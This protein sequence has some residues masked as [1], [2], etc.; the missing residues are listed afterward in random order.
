M[1]SEDLIIDTI[2]T[3]TGKIPIV[4]TALNYK[5]RLGVLKMRL[6]IGRMEYAI[7]PGLYAVGNPDERSPVLVSANYKLSF[8]YLRKELQNFNAW[9]L[10]LDTKGIN[11]WCA[12]GKGTFGTDELIN[13]IEA[14]KLGKIVN[15]RQVIL[16]Q[17]SA[18]GVAAHLVKQATGFK[19]RYGPIR[20]VDLPAF[21]QSDFEATE[22][23]R[24]VKFD[25]IDRLALIPLEVIKA[26]KYI[27]IGIILLFFLSGL[28]A[29]GY[30]VTIAASSL[31]IINTC[32]L[33]AFLAGAVLTPLLLPYIPGRAFALKG[34]FMNG[35]LFILLYFVL[36]GFQ[37]LHV[38]EIIAWFLMMSAIV[39]FFAMNFTGASTFTSLSGVKKEMRFAV[40]LQII[41]MA[42]GLLFWVVTRIA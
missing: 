39:S 1:I 11:V 18:P 21:L 8:D 29:K 17:L 40:P 19:V 2:E 26:F 14:T 36:P 13:K 6:N 33:A 7:E 10:V 32:I 20:A 35:P 3:P 15:H 38:L 27:L 31:V 34:F 5:D 41:S 28:H 25:L 12:A 23:M 16:P 37:N 4:P 22:E 9:I 42:L 24:T 30:S